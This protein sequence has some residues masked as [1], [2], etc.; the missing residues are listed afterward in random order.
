[1]GTLDDYIA[2]HGAMKLSESP[3]G[4]KA[5]AEHQKRY[6]KEILTPKDPRFQKVY[7]KQLKEQERLHTK[8]VEASKAYRERFEWKKKKNENQISR[9]RIK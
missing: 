9:P 7:G 5:L 6:W 1:M 3:E 2:R 8:K 4:R